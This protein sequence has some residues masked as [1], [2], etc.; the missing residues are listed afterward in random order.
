MD[1]LKNHR[2]ETENAVLDIFNILKLEQDHSR[3]CNSLKKKTSLEGVE[4]ISFRLIDSSSLK[5]VIRTEGFH[6][7]QESKL[8]KFLCSLDIR[9]RPL[10]GL[11][12]Y[13]S[14]FYK[15]LDG[16]DEFWNVLVIRLMLFHLAN[17]SVIPTLSFLQSLEHIPVVIK[18]NVNA[19][20]S[21]D[22]S[23]IPQNGMK[24]LLKNKSM[25]TLSVLSLLKDFFERF[26]RASASYK[27]HC[28]CLK[29]ATVIP[30]RQL[31]LG[32][33]EAH[34]AKDFAHKLRIGVSGGIDV[35]TP[36]CVQDFFDMSKN[37]ASKVTASELKR[38]QVGCLESY[39]KLNKIM[40]AGEQRLMDLFQFPEDVSI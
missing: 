23:R 15:I 4:L 33:E 25:Y 38:L 21:Y 17:R 24:N 40:N 19:S 39:E 28:I 32:H 8:I 14:S 1:P 29:N 20:F 10:L 18:N 6:V 5:C 16:P 13:W 26:A 35:S 9:V 7:V 37:V 11:A 27:E 22:T 30:R 12:R 2:E 3:F 31:E 36:M 34:L